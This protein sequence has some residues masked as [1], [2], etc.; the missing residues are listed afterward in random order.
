MKTK[1]AYTLV[2][3]NVDNRKPTYLPGEETYR[4]ARWRATYLAKTEDWIEV[5][6]VERVEHG[7][8]IVIG[9]YDKAGKWLPQ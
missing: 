2:A 3:R 9:L 4:S 6:E 1:R 5:V 8:S 7:T